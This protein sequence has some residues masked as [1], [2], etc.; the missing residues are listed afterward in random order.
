VP[1]TAQC[2]VSCTYLH[3]INSHCSECTVEIPSPK[4]IILVV[5]WN[6]TEFRYISLGYE[7]FLTTDML[8]ECLFALSVRVTLEI[9]HL[10]EFLT[11]LYTFSS[12]P[13][14]HASTWANRF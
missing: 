2:I 8:L 10:E 14:L 12:M 4:A 6:V 7:S 9:S 3:H 13:I 11:F 1:S 5:F